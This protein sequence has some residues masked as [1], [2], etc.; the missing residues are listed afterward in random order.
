MDDKEEDI[1][2]R[3]GEFKEILG[4]VPSWILRWGITMVAIIVIVL[5]IGSA[6]FKYPDVITAKITL[7]GNVPTAGIVAKST[8]K[9]QEIYV[10]DKQNVFK[11]EYL[12]SIENPANV[13]DVLYL[14]KYVNILN[15]I[16]LT[17][18]IPLLPSRNMNI[19]D[20]QSSYTSFWM[21]LAEYIQFKQLNYYGKKIDL[22]KHRILKYQ[23]YF[24]NM[25]RQYELVTMQAN[26]NFRQYA[27]DSVLHRKSL[28][29]DE[30]IE[31]SYYSFLQGK[32]SQ[33]NMFTTIENI[34]MQIEEMKEALLDTEYQFAD[35]KQ[36]LENQLRT[37]LSQLINSIQTWEMNYI[38]IS[39]LDGCITFTKYWVIN[40][41]IVSGNEVFNIIPTHNN[42]LIGKAL[43]PISRSGKVKIGQRVNVRFD[44]FPDEEFGIIR[45]VVDNISLV[46]TKEDNV[47]QY[48]LEIK[49]PNGLN[50]TYN[51][52]IPFLSEM[53]GKADIVTDDLSLLERF[54]LPIKKIFKN[55]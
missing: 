1:E 43:L 16:L 25:K 50:S 10:K 7:T 28:I 22:T 30:E 49:F 39:P 20:I 24:N 40:Q 46:P 35:K 53:E 23:E 33:E 18:S 55:S 52:K 9:I 27:R 17:D 26:I 3:G 42:E 37:Q 6:L 29:S 5:L 45:G 19:G 48:S 15:G 54:F 44:N 11:G 31:K 36:I 41:N 21:A 38:L 13:E 2:L 34:Q 12:A 4:E 32:L 14:K 51:K 8:G 47:S